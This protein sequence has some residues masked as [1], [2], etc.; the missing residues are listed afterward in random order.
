MKQV[1][2]ASGRAKRN[3]VDTVSIPNFVTHKKDAG[4]MYSSSN[5]ELIGKLAIKREAKRI[6][7]CL[8]FAI[9]PL[10][11]NP[12][13]VE[14]RLQLG[15]KKNCAEVL[16]LLRKDPWD[17]K[18][19]QAR[20]ETEMLLRKMGLHGLRML[21]MDEWTRDRKVHIMLCYVI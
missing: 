6:C 12:E 17:N 9:L 13:K 18:T 1:A 16:E 7:E 15:Y 21:Q 20:R 10:L 5:W 14:A 11:G 8:D 4:L 19:D 3:S 2:K